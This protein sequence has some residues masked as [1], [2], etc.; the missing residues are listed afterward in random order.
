MARWQEVAAMSFKGWTS[1]NVFRHSARARRDRAKQREVREEEGR[2]A[3]RRGDVGDEEGPLPRLTAA[4]E[5]EISRDIQEELL[6]SCSQITTTCF[7][8]LSHWFYLY[9]ARTLARATPTQTHTHSQVSST[10]C[11]WQLILYMLFP[12]EHCRWVFSASVTK[13]V[14]FWEDDSVGESCGVKLFRI[15]F[16]FLHKWTKIQKY[17]TGWYQ[18]LSAA[19]EVDWRETENWRLLI[20]CIAETCLHPTSFDLEGLY[21]GTNVLQ[22][23]PGVSTINEQINEPQSCWRWHASPSVENVRSKQKNND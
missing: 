23:W 4:A 17:F 22:T 1:S 19:W 10:R 15:F 21:Q 20:R 12:W 2:A 3:W 5:F 18:N 8:L 7:L 11:L 13:A 6:S 9:R 16:F 14:G